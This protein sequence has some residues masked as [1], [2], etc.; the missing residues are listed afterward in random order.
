MD[1]GRIAHRQRRARYPEEE[2][3]Q[4]LAE[5]EAREGREYTP[6]EREAFAIA[7]YS[8]D[9]RREIRRLAALGITNEDE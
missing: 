1:E 7:F 3:R 9:Y 6:R 8:E 2:C 4:A 5:A